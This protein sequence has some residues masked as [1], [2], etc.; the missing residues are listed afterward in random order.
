ML[1]LSASPP[2]RSRVYPTS[3]ALD[4]RTRASPSSVASP[5]ERWG[6]VRGGGPGEFGARLRQ[7]RLADFARRTTPHPPTPP[8]RPSR[9]RRGALAA[10]PRSTDTLIVRRV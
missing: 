9:G 8:H 4:C 3:A 5:C 10:R 1:G 7:S 6:G 2:S